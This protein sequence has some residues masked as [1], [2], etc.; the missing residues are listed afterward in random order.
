MISP[1]THLGDGAQ[2]FAGVAA[3]R[4]VGARALSRLGLDLL[5]AARHFQVGGR[6]RR[7]LK[8]GGRSRLLAADL[9]RL[10]GLGGRRLVF[11]RSMGQA[12]L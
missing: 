8:Q 4:P 1:A 2:I 12:W 10:L 3:Q 9:L 7:R 6:R 11:L 5:E